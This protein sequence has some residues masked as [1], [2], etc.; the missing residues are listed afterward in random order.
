MQLLLHFHWLYGIEFELFSR[1]FRLGSVQGEGGLADL[2]RQHRC[3]R[4]FI[5]ECFKLIRR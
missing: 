2:G 5:K 4:Y 1:D 3:H